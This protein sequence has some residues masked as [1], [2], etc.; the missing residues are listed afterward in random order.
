VNAIPNIRLGRV[1]CI[2]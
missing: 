2:L 1:K